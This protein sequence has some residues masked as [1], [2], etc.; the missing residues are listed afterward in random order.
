MFSTPDNKYELLF[1]NKKK[2]ERFFSFSP[3]ASFVLLR[4]RHL[5][6]ALVQSDLRSQSK[7]HPG[8]SSVGQGLRAPSGTFRENQ[9]FRS[10]ALVKEYKSF[11]ARNELEEDIAH[12]YCY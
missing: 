8:A 7:A 9:S 1:K 3:P 2:R 6:D 10:S 4:L 5:A 11:A 12:A